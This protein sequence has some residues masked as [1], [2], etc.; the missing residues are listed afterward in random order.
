MLRQQMQLEPLGAYYAGPVAANGQAEAFG[1][2]QHRIGSVFNAFYRT[3]RGQWR[4][5]AAI[6][7]PLTETVNGSPTLVQYYQFGRLELNPASGSVE[8]SRFGQRAY[9]DLCRANGQ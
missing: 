5:G 2:G 1:P 8:A 3:Y 4:L 9:T 7:E 6:S